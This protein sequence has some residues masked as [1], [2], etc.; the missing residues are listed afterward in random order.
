MA[1]R[2][3]CEAE[4]AHRTSIDKV[5]VVSSGIVFT[6]CGLPCATRARA[7]SFARWSQ[8]KANARALGAKLMSYGYK[9][10]TD[11]TVNHLVL[12]DLRKEVRHQPSRRSPLAAYHSGVGVTS[13]PSTRVNPAHPGADQLP[14]IHVTVWC[15]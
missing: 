1:D 5:N 4:W 13:L 10:V 11:G 9:L 15:L 2:Q 7:E 8:V 12:W 6:Q 14:Q 3:R